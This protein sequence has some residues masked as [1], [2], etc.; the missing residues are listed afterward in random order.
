MW[1]FDR[2]CVDVFNVENQPPHGED[3]ILP[4]LLELLAPQGYRHLVRIG[5]D[6]VFRRDPP[7]SAGAGGAGP[8]AH[9]KRD[10]RRLLRRSDRRRRS[11]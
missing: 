7:C 1:P 2:W 4:K 10:A 11:A 8:A 9:A 5:V 3:S 6:E